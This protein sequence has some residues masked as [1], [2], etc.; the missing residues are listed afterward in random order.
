[1]ILILGLLSK[2][3]QEENTLINLKGN[4]LKKRYNR[5]LN[6]SLKDTSFKY[7]NCVKDILIFKHFLYI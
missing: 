6:L 1:M 7:K 3:I 2:S 5:N 4:N